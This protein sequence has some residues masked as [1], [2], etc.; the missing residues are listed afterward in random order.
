MRVGFVRSVKL[1]VAAVVAFG[2]AGCDDSPTDFETTET[3]A[4]STNPS[5]MILGAGLT[6]ILESRALNQGAAPTWEEV[7]WMIDP[8]C[9]TTTPAGEI[10]V[11]ISETYE[12][13]G[14]THPV[15]PPGVFD[16]TGGTTLGETCIQLSAA[17]ASATVEVTVVADSMEI[18]NAPATIEPATGTTTAQLSAAL[19]ADDGQPVSP[20]DPLTDVTWSSDNE[21][22]LTV[23]DTGLVTAVG[24]GSATITASFTSAGRTVEDQVTIEVLVPAPVLNSTDA[25]TYDYGDLVTVD[26]TG[27]IPGF[28]VIFVDGFAVD[29]L[30]ATIVDATTAT[31]HMPGAAAAGTVDITI[32]V[33][34]DVSNP[35]TVTRDDSLEP[36]NDLPNPAVMVSL[37]V[38]LYSYVDGVDANDFYEFTLVAETTFDM[39]LDWT[40]SADLDLIITNAT[41]SAFPCFAASTAHPESGECTL[42]A[43]T[44]YLWINDYDGVPATY[45][46]QLTP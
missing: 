41:L 23:D 28:H 42:G 33:P 44:W 16:V 40:G 10:S 46:A 25:G 20:F 11:A 9:A 5:A 21:D 37:P 38:D 3:V 14:D 2:L 17:G 29:P 39:F 13:D 8:S 24:P 15:R 35:L 36:A 34:G 6:Q 27:L 32:G 26:A 4:I 45:N 12:G 19:L 1:G 31:F 30:L 18:L 7:D 22:V 43:G